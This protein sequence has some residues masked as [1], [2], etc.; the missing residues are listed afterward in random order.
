MQNKSDKKLRLSGYGVE[1]QMKS[2]EYKV[3]D[4]SQVKD[5]SKSEESSQEEEDVELEGFNFARLK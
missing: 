1:L 2:T 3:Q 4:D 5:D